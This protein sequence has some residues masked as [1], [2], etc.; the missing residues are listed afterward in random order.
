MKNFS[1]ACE[2]RTQAR[3]KQGAEKAHAGRARSRQGADGAV[4]S[5]DTGNGAIS[6]PVSGRDLALRA[7]VMWHYYTSVA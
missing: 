7:A 2:G 5:N 3:H 6:D 1:S 4:S